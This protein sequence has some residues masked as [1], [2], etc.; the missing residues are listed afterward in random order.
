MLSAGVRG[1]DWPISHNDES[2]SSFFLFF[3][4]FHHFQPM[5]CW[6]SKLVVWMPGNGN[7][8]GCDCPINCCVAILIQFVAAAHK[9]VP[10]TQ[11][12]WCTSER[13]DIVVIVCKP[14]DTTII[15]YYYYGFTIMVVTMGL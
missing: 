2:Q 15:N 1:P 8:P 7:I 4:M 13:L 9:V 3:W 6:W 11:L 5:V 12:S 10:H 14:T